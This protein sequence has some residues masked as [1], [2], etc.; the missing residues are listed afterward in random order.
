M[1]DTTH[2]SHDADT[3]DLKT[4]TTSIKCLI[5]FITGQSTDDKV[6]KI[7]THSFHHN[8][9]ISE[10]PSKNEGTVQHATLLTS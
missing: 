9:D 1:E 3:N 10:K 2:R 4:P 5:T 8:H 6:P 7:F